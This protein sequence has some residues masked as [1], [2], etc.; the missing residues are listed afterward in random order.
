MIYTLFFV[1]MASSFTFLLTLPFS[2][3]LPNHCHSISTLSLLICSVAGS[4]C[5]ALHCLSI[6]CLHSYVQRPF[7]SLCSFPFFLSIQSLFSV[8]PILKTHLVLYFSPHLNLCSH[9]P[10]YFPFMYLISICLH[11]RL[12]LTHTATQRRLCKPRDHFL[13]INFGGLT[14]TP[15]L[16]VE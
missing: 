5:L 13:P 16:T 1:I 12:S 14:A 15:E 7:H 3:I 9:L 8:S 2:W 4:L 10:F 6:V 11:A